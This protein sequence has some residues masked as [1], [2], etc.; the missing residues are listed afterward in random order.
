M[1]T[2]YPHSIA[3]HEGLRT[4]ADRAHEDGFGAG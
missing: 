1:V 3:S 4:T 2:N